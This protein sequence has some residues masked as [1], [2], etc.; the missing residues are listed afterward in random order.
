MDTLDVFLDTFMKLTMDNIYISVR[1]NF[2]KKTIIVFRQ[3]ESIF[4]LHIL[5]KFV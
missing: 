4:L 5:R 3:N 2:Q 1:R